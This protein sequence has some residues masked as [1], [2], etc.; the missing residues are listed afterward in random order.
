MR[1]IYPYDRKHCLGQEEPIFA[2]ASSYA[3]RVVTILIGSRKGMEHKQE[4]DDHWKAQ[5]YPRDNGEESKG[6]QDWVPSSRNAENG[7]YAG[8]KKGRGGDYNGGV[9]A[10]VFGGAAA[11]AATATGGVYIS[12]GGEGG[13]V[14]RVL[15]LLML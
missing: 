8:L 11:A 13:D 14:S 2:S 15:L 4:P 3:Q 12:M 9:M 7:G 1:S 10:I 6:K 5:Y